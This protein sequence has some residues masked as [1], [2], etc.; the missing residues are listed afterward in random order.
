MIN[1]QIGPR[2]RTHHI[3]H[4]WKKRYCSMMLTAHARAERP[5]KSETVPSERKNHHTTY[6]RIVVY[7]GNVRIRVS[8]AAHIV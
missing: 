8:N 7:K 1:V 2:A 3:T 5:I 4:H 6:A